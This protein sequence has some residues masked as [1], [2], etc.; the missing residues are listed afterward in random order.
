MGDKPKPPPSKP[1]PLNQEIL[2]GVLIDAISV[3]IGPDYFILDGLV[4]KP[5]S[6]KPY[7]VS[8]MMIP[9]RM[10]ETFVSMLNG[11][12]EAHKKRIEE[13]KKKAK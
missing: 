7:I 12:L 1:E 3:H 13:T 4:A 8:R 10:L 9:T 5:R 2:K 6:D 11:L